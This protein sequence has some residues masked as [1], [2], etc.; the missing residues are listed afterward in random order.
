MTLDA[1]SMTLKS[2]SFTIIISKNTPSI[3]ISTIFCGKNL[4]A[5]SILSS[6]TVKFR[7]TATGLIL[8]L[9]FGDEMLIEISQSGA[10]T[11]SVS[12]GSSY[13]ISQSSS[14]VIFGDELAIEVFLEINAAGDPELNIYVDGAR[15]IKLETVEI[16]Y[17]QNIQI[18]T[19]A[20]SPG[21]G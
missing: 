17:F 21:S 10:S 19:S 15:I 3:L 18:V 5:C 2:D 20:S 1:P 8:A 13:G 7:A 11:I 6:V 9:A 16:K 4:E 12:T 14:S